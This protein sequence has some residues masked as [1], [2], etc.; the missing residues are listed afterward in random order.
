MKT[1]K[2]IEEQ[3]RKR[4]HDELKGTNKGSGSNES[5][6]PNH[7]LL[8]TGADIDS[9][10]HLDS[11]PGFPPFVR[12]T[13]A[14]MYAGRLWTIRQYAGYSTAAESNAFYKKALAAGQT[15]L[16]VAF[17]LPTHRGYDSDH[18]RVTA[19]VGKAGV[20]IDSVEDMKM[21]FQ[22]ISLE[23]TSV[24]MTMSGAVIPILAH[25]L[26]AAEEQGCAYGNL[27]GTIQNDILKEFVVRNT[28]IYPPRASMRIST[29]VV[30]FISKH[31]PRFNSLSVSGYH[32]QEAGATP[33][34]ELAFA[35]ADGR[36]YV[37]SVVE[38]GLD[39]DDFAGRISFF[40]AIGSNF[41]T[42]VAKLRAARLLWCRV[43]AE[44]KPE[45]PAS[46]ML[47]THCQTSGVSLHAHDPYNN[48]VRTAY[49]AMAAVLGGT[50]SLHTNALDETFAPPSEFSARLARNTQLILQHET[51]ITDV[52]DP[53]GGSYYVEALTDQIANEAWSLIEKISAAGGM[54]TAI[55]NGMPQRMIEQAAIQRQVA[56]DI[57]KETIIGVNKY[58]LEHEVDIDLMKV[59]GGLVSQL[60]I[61]ALQNVKRRR[62]KRSV[63]AA[64]AALKHVAQTGIGNL[65]EAAISAS[66][67]RA[68][69]GEIS[70]T[71]REI[72]GEHKAVPS[73]SEPIYSNACQGDPQFAAIQS[74]ISR[75][76]DSTGE[77]PRMLIS[78][79]GQD[80]HDRAAKTIESA[81]R[82]M[83]FET[84][85]SPLF[86]TPEEVADVAKRRNVHILG[87]SA[88]TGAHNVLVPELMGLLKDKGLGHIVVVCG[89]IVPPE[90]H[91]KLNA[92]G[93][94]S[95][96]GP[97]TNLFDAAHVILDF[98]EG[99]KRNFE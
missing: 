75:I 43:M 4:V 5:V 32:F 60:Q 23:N 41:F 37:R 87:V 81:F 28:Y 69:V 53:L 14:S 39:V 3:W 15:G 82:D 31:M 62:D 13:R 89:G 6:G 22:D 16:S 59:D 19:D 97:N 54:A 26:I 86:Q 11:F 25:F 79:L 8:Y 92:F 73:V 85:L 33:V 45:R 2:S 17:D 66:R 99:K 34:Q 38:R 71:L 27:S 91:V 83:G 51:G 72:F 40:F 48:I 49:E 20:A 61:K 57:G 30:E 46:S 56:F 55:A 35:L 44:F 65:L 74:R 67:V 76:V 90:D 93:V 50:Q 10:A 29:D 12:G 58:R 63:D 18:P 80:G 96:F 42:E 84:F 98:F 94:R 95:I 70:N 36:E 52:I 64:L 88:H 77:R 47:R 9:L 68:T 1:T 21:L 7:K 78:T 24:S